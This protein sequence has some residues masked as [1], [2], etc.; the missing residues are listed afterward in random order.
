MQLKYFLV[1]G[2]VLDV[3][4]AGF[5]LFVSSLVISSF[6]ARRFALDVS[7]GYRR[8]IFLNF[9]RSIFGEAFS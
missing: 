5:F 9:G 1:T 3:H 6:S 4:P 7:S 2:K 8:G